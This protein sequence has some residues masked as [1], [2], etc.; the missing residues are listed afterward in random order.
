MIDVRLLRDAI[1]SHAQGYYNQWGVNL[2]DFMSLPGIAEHIAYKYYDAKAPPIY[3][4]GKMF[5]D[6]NAEIRSQ[7]YGGMVMVFH[8]LICLDHTETNFPESAYKA[9]NNEEFKLLSFLDFNSL[10]PKGFSQSLPCGPGILFEK[11]GSQ[12]KPKSL[13]W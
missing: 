7:L 2:H 3:S 6:L 4:F 1:S 9:A 10:Y 5:G 12:F 11:R 13:N 8:R